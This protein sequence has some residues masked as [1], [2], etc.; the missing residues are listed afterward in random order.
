[1]AASR[2]FV[3]VGLRSA[4]W[5]VYLEPNGV[6]VAPLED[7]IEHVLGE[8]CICGPRP[9]LYTG[10]RGEDV[11]LYVHHSLDGREAHE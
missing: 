9:E 11:W 3:T 5:A 8:E 10:P 2:P 7:A 4:R 6:H 1:M